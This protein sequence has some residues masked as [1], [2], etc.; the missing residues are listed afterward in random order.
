MHRDEMSWDY[1]SKDEMI[2]ID[3]SRDDIRGD[4]M[5]RN[6]TKKKSNS[7]SKIFNQKRGFN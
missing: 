1:M 4:E 5:S 2:G 3:M 7:N 6:G